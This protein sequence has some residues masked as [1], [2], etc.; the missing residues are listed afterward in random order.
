MR[1]SSCSNAIRAP[2]PYPR[3]RRARATWTSEVVTS[4]PAGRPSRIPTRAGPCDSPAVNH[5]SM[6]LILPRRL[7]RAGGGPTHG[8]EPINLE[9]EVA[10]SRRRATTTGG[11][12]LLSSCGEAGDEE[13][14]V[15]RRLDVAEEGRTF[16]YV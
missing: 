13:Q 9:L 15:S 12:L 4:T 7:A 2:R 10:R 5:R 11:D 8:G 14:P 16:G 6:P 1:T 3:R